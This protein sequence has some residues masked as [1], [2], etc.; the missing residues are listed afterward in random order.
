MY[1]LVF[2]FFPFALP[3]AFTL[4]FLLFCPSHFLTQ[5]HR[6]L[7]RYLLGFLLQ[8]F[9]FCLVWQVGGLQLQVSPSWERVILEHEC[10]RSLISARSI[11]GQQMSVPGFNPKGKCWEKDKELHSAIK[12]ELKKTEC[13][14]EVFFFPLVRPE[15][16]PSELKSCQC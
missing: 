8:C 10:S 9:G 4:L 7:L 15:L 5:I 6:R 3:L 12:S 2:L 11:T 13:V 14:G 1:L 16:F